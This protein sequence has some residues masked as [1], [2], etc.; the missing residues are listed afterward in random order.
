MNYFYLDPKITMPGYY[1]LQNHLDLIPWFYTDG[2]PSLIPCRLLHMTYEDYLNFCAERLGAQVSR[3]GAYAAIYFQLNQNTRE[4]L[5]VINKLFNKS[6]KF[7]ESEN[8]ITTQILD[9]IYM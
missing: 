8:L 6:L 4:F 2:A 1:V 3:T 9:I 5:E 7:T